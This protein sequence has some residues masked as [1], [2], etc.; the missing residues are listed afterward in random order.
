MY[1]AEHNA[2]QKDWLRNSVTYKEPKG[3]PKSAV[4]KDVNKSHILKI[5]LTEAN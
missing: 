2:I 3:S 4:E 1:F 5:D